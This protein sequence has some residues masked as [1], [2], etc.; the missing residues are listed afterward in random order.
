MAILANL[1][2]IALVALFNTTPTTM[3]EPASFPYLRDAKFNN[4]SVTPWVTNTSLDQFYVARSD[5]TKHTLLPKWTTGNAFYVPF[6]PSDTRNPSDSFRANTSSLAANISCFPLVK[7]T[8]NSITLNLTKFNVVDIEINVQNE[9]HSVRCTPRLGL[10]NTDPRAIAGW[11]NGS[12]ALELSLLMGPPP[13]DPSSTPDA[14]FCREIV[15]N[16]WIRA[17]INVNQTAP[18][19]PQDEPNF[20]PALTI[21]RWD[22]MFLGC[23]TIVSV[24]KAE[25]IVDGVGN[26]QNV[27]SV[28][29]SHLTD[30]DLYI[31]RPTDLYGQLAAYFQDTA[32]VWHDDSHP[33]NWNNY[34]LG[35]IGNTTDLVDPKAPVPKYEDVAPLLS[36][37][38]R[39]IFAIFL[40]SN[41]DT[42]LS[43]PPEGASVKGE[44]ISLTSRVFL[45][46]RMFWII[47]SILTL[48]ILVAIPL[49]FSRPKPFL[50]RLPTTIASVIAY[51]A[52]SHA[53][54]DFRGTSDMN[55][56]SR[57]RH[58]REK[59][60]EYLFGDYVGT[61]KK[62][63]T[64]IER[65]PFAVPMSSKQ[66]G[67]T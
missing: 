14:D 64:G 31:G 57:E 37:L 38:Y 27:S 61:D 40:S 20:D 24:S 19:T 36:D 50:P 45:T 28:E 66:K 13:E 35:I 41:T 11:A 18:N 12:M 52:A 55:R 10:D 44:T 48:Y 25:V 54:L 9:G 49:Y 2:A 7:G 51:F 23:R 56:T 4:I 42:L 53:L 67:P 34:L 1:L 15:V 22:Q 58:I 47:E 21:N 33:S 62:P 32:G 65:V 8:E 5:L 59:D 43:K 46:E 17:D 26:I 39:R 6:R 30:Q 16:G 3:H 63:H 29:S 60:R